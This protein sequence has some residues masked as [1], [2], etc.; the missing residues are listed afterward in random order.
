MSSDPNAVLQGLAGAL[1][2]PSPRAMVYKDLAFQ[3]GIATSADARSLPG[4]YKDGNRVRFHEPFP[5]KERGWAVIPLNGANAGVYIGTARGN[6]DW[7]SLDNQEW[8]AWGTECKLY[9]ENNGTLYDVTPLRKSSNVMNPFTTTNTSNVVT[10]HDPDNRANDGDHIN[11]DGSVTFN[12]V[13]IGGPYDIASIIDPD[14]Y[15]IVVAAHATSSGSGGGSVTIEYDINCGLAENG[16]LLGY[17]TGLYGAGTYGTPRTVGT[18]VPAKMR[19]WS[20]QNFG[21]DL[22]ASYS[23]GEIYWWDRTTGPNSRAV[24]ISDAPTSVQR[25]IVNP[26]T[27]FIIAIGAS[28]AI[29]NIPDEMN[30]RWASEG[31]IAGSWVP[32]VL[33]TAN[34]AG[35][36]R[37][38]YGSKLVTGLQSRD[39]NLIWSDNFLYAMQFIGSPNIFGF[40]DLGKTSIAGPNAAIDVNGTAY[41]MGLDDFFIYDGTLRPIPCEVWTYIFGKQNVNADD[42]PSPGDFDRTQSE[43]VYCS[44]FQSKNE[45]RWHYPTVSDGM[46]YVTYNYALNCWYYGKMERTVYSDVSPAIDPSEQYPYG[47]NGGYLYKHEFGYDEV[48]PG[49]VTNAMDWFLETW[50]IGMQSDVPML[51]NQLAP[52]FPKVRGTVQLKKGLQFRLLPLEFPDQPDNYINGDFGPFVVTPDCDQVD[53][54]CLGTQTALRFEAARATWTD[55]SGTHTDAIV[56]GQWF[57]LGT[58]QALAGPYGKRIDMP[59][60]GSPID[61]SGP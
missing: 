7:T 32:Q 12:G 9:L 1:N 59:R 15:T 39:Q 4:R 61:T 42:T 52:A 49:N 16:E 13:T 37:L 45:V 5:E 2:R 24:L 31:T 56:Y 60:P 57:R 22:I 34:T 14:H 23:D 41:W 47:L 6:H 26:E 25:V 20:L 40:R 11:V 27:Q 21:E 55:G 30:V 35:G 44:S 54:R 48:E 36:Q 50:D 10:V 28:D 29:T 8:I 19:T 17:G 51:I 43:A 58:W 3:P 46:H 38:T 18:G 33:P 53:V